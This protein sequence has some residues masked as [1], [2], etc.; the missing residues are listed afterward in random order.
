MAGVAVA[1]ARGAEPGCGGAE[2]LPAGGAGRD[3]KGSPCPPLPAPF[4]LRRCR[5][6]PGNAWGESREPREAPGGPRG[7]GRGEPRGCGSRSGPGS[8]GK[9]WLV[10]RLWGSS[11]EVTRVLFHGL[12]HSVRCRLAHPQVGWSKVI[13]VNPP[14]GKGKALLAAEKKE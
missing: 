4:P 5:R 14:V 10:L 9:G 1:A 8:L 6:E 12:M 2:P 13:G 11:G 3:G 7:A